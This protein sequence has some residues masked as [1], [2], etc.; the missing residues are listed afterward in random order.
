MKG[1]EQITY[2][3]RRIEQIT[4][5]AMHGTEQITYIQQRTEANK[6]HIQQ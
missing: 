6:S 1:N 2:S 4:Y 5:T 3:N